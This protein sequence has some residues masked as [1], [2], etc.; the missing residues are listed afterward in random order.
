MLGGQLALAALQPHAGR[1][2][3]IT[4]LDCGLLPVYATTGGTNRPLRRRPRALPD[5][6]G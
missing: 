1:I 6:K 2:L 3:K 5:L 4:S